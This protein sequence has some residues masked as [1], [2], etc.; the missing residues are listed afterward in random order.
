MHGNNEPV[1]L[2]CTLILILIV[3]LMCFVTFY[4]EK[5]T[6]QVISD[7]KA[8]LPTSCIVIRDCKK[9]Q[10][11]EEELVTGDLVV[12]SAGAII[13]ADMR[14]LQSNGLKIETSAITGDKDAY[15][16]TH[17]AVTTYPSVFEARNVAFKGSFC[18]EGDGIGIVVRTGK[19]TV[20]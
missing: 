9:Q 8:V 17:E 19:Y 4:Q 6:L 11:P 16:Y 1:N 14:I 7:L 5:Q 10:V 18:L 20:I 2:Y 12:I 13:P 3:I 15:D